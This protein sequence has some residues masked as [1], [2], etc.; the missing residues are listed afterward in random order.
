MYIICTYNSK[1][2]CKNIFICIV[3][4]VKTFF[5]LYI[6]ILFILFNVCTIF[7]IIHYYVIYKKKN[8]NQYIF[9]FIQVYVY[10][11]NYINIANN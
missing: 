2:C 4:Y 3:F 6:L 1:M 7:T 11:N 8:L 5:V 10:I 9:I